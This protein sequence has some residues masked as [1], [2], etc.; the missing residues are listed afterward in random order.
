MGGDAATRYDAPPKLLRTRLSTASVLTQ[1][2]KMN[3]GK[4]IGLSVTAALGLALFAD[5]SVG[6]Q[7]PLRDQLL[8]TWALV[9][10]IST[11]ADGSKF[12]AYGANPKGIAFFDA[13]G[14]FIITAMRADRARYAVDFPTQGTDEENKATAQGTIT[15]YGTYSV[16]EADRT[17]AIH[18]EASSFPNWNG[19]DQKRGFAIAGDQLTLTARALQTGGSAD[20]VWRRVQ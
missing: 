12:P 6:Q 20:V 7:R 8:G 13:G 10:H 14:H 5:S 17:I 4:F 9:S 11:R 1:G 15:Y 18:I 16:N 2:N 19:A 3:R